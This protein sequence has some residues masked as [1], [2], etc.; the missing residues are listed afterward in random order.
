ME[1]YKNLG[2]DS[3]VLAYGLGQGQITV[4]FSNGW[5]YLYTI[6]STGAANICEMQRLA[7]VGLGLNSYIAKVVR[8]TYAKK[9]R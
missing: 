7:S 6:Q 2:G 9:W 3:S 5:S 8:K 4:L 1:R